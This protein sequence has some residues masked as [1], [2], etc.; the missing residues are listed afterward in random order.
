MSQ[1]RPLQ[2]E[3]RTGEKGAAHR[4]EEKM[5]QVRLM[6]FDSLGEDLLV[7]WCCYGHRIDELS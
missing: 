3:P 1:G 5:A 4:E 6:R 7:L 2:S